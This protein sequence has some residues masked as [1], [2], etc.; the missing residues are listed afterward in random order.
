MEL[1]QLQYFVKVAKKQHVTHAAEELHIAQ[2]AVSRQIHQLEEQLG[3][4]LFLQQGRNLQLTP[5]GKLFLKR[6]EAILADLERSIQET[7]EFMDP[8]LGEIRL[9]FPHSMG[10]HLVP[11]VVSTF[12]HEHNKVNFKLKQGKY[13]QLIQ[14][15]MKAETD[16]AFISPFPE[17]HDH[18]TGDLLITEDL[19]AVFPPKHPLAQKESISLI[20]LKDEPFVLF[21]EGFSLRSIVIEACAKAGFIPKISFESDE[22]DTIRGLVAAGMGVSLLPEI[23]LKFSCTPL[24]P[25]QVKIS[26]QKVTRTVGIIHRK[27]EKL[28]PVAEV[29]KQ[30]I[31]H[32]IQEHYSK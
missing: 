1:R 13:D 30:F 27:N 23:A 28:P 9:G 11:M 18:V 26:D 17:K 10:V 2:S 12:K 14:S 7:R 32:Y 3:V 24:Q 5:V 20:D 21:N 31:V 6:V 16:L 15:V 22:T 19:Y 25:V 29:F 4:N 8:E